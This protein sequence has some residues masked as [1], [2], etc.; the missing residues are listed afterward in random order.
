MARRAAA[1]GQDFSYFPLGGGL[2]LIT[3]AIAQK[4]G[5]AIA[6]LN[7][8][9]ALNGYRRVEGYERFDGR[10]SPTDASYW[11]LNFITGTIEISEGTPVTG[12]TSGATGVALAD[13][14]LTSG[15]WGSG[16]AVGYV[17]LGAVTGTF[18]NGEALN[19][20]SVSLALENGTDFVLEDGVTT[21]DAETGVAAAHVSGT[22]QFLTAP[23]DTTATAWQAQATENARA[24]IQ[25][26]PGEGNILG[27]WALNGTL[28]AFRNAVGSAAAA[29]FKNSSTGW[30]AVA[31]GYTVD[32]TSG[33]TYQLQEGDVIVGDTSTKTATV[34]RVVKQ[35]GSWSAGTAAGYVVIAAASGA[36]TAAETVH[37]GAHADVMTLTADK[38]A[39][40]LPP[41]GRYEFANHNFY[42]A[43]KTLRMYGVNGVGRAF[44]FDGA[45]FT[46]IRSGMTVDTPTK[47]AVHVEHL[48]LG[49]PGGAFQNSSIGL[50]L[51]WSA[52]T[53]AAA[54]GM[55]DEISDFI[56]SNAGVLTVLGANKVASLYGTS[57]ADFQLKD[58]S[59]ESGAMPHTASVVGEPIYLDARGLRSISTTQN[60]GDFA[61]GSLSQ[62]VKPLLQ[63][64]QRANI[65][66]VACVRVR[67]KD[68]YRLFFSNG[69]AL[70]FYFG[71]IQA[72]AGSYYSASPQ[73][74]Q[75]D[76]LPF[77]WG[78]TVTCVGSFEM[79][80]G[81]RIFFGST[82]GY[83]YEADKGFSFDGA[84][85]S[86]S[87]RLPFNHQK[88]PQTKKRWH[89]VTVECQ[90]APSATISVSADFDYGDPFEA[91][92]SPRD[93]VAQ[94][95]TVSGGGGVWD[96]SNW[97]QFA[98][99]SATEGLMEADLDGVG[100]NM[101][102]LIAGSTS[103]EPPHLLQGLT[104]FFTV[105]GLQR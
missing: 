102:L 47:I 6:A 92:S 25:K 3:P 78:K 79:T 77:N 91:G 88:M 13:A 23:D 100:R 59:G 66:P 31:L 28:Y 73:Q 62:K 99:S 26:V 41:G 22:Q 15:T 54:Y 33:G 103:D 46:P 76:V 94:V 50:P 71:S 29:M 44:E 80:T 105:R 14:V 61:L 104:L 36:F 34:L 58:V 97:N 96:I 82:D 63:D 60:Y 95:F 9:P 27:V 83:V 93:A 65:T 35:S 5:S 37:V 56:P 81:E 45:I 64:Y 1:A 24:L 67:H 39:I 11:Q 51:D 4:P 90:A 69:D 10:P 75:P 43:S 85:I 16:D 89:K 55:G 42:G 57:S 48:F 98:W 21:L 32:F 2:D 17:G 72:M 87:L 19:A 74:Q 7:Y 101:S 53:G 40:T 30:Q 68:H 84:K 38:V 8:E 49:F 70:A 52:V 86:H 12:A 18:I 20:A